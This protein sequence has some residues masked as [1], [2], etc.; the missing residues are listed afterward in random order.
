MVNPTNVDLHSSGSG[1][2]LTGFCVTKLLMRSFF[3]TRGRSPCPM[4]LSRVAC[5]HLPVQWPFKG[6]VVIMDPALN[7]ILALDAGFAV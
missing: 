2:Q 6:I 7:A 4:R 3:Q 5:G 1:P